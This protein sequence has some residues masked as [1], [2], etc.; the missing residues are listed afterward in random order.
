MIMHHTWRL[1]DSGVGLP[2]WNMAVDEALI[3]THSEGDLPIIRL[4]GWTNA[5]SIGKFSNIHKS[6]DLKKLNDRK[7]PIVRRM[8]GGGIL[9]HGNDLSYSLILPR[10]FMNIGVKESYRYLCKFLIRLYKNLGHTACFAG[11]GPSKAAR[12][13]ICLAGN[14]MYD[15]VINKKK[16]GGNAQRYTRHV[17]FQHGTVPMR[18]DESLFNPVFTEESGLKT[19]ASLERLGTVMSYESLLLAV[20][21]AFCET[22]NVVLLPD[23]LTQTEESCAQTLL[24][25]KYSQERWNLHGKQASA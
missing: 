8:S 13:A 7:L 9:V 22:F 17:L 11:E 24:E 20:K 5:L 16:M 6:L 3:H 23:T 1:I 2:D 12:S 4:Y 15:I 10:S 18:L 21:E 25:H 14:E 19:A